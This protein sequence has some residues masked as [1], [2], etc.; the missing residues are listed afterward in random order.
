MSQDN[1]TT[2]VGQLIGPSPYPAPG[3]TLLPGPLAS[4]VSL[5][6]R[7]TTVSIRLGSLIGGTALDAARIGTLTGL[8]L[9]RAAVEGILARAGRDVN[10]RRAAG[11]GEEDVEGWTKTGVSEQ[12]IFVSGPFPDVLDLDKLATF[13]RI[14][15][16]ATPLDWFRNIFNH[17]CDHLRVCRDLCPNPRFH[18]RIHGII[19]CHLRNRNTYSQRIQ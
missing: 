8:E 11:G 16:P 12:A 4:L 5:F 6:S 7:S 10:S 3:P 13:L 18:L 19:T 15:Y 2:T 1:E 17:A 9:G 14:T